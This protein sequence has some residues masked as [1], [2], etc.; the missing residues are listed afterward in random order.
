VTN[1]TEARAD[2]NFLQNITAS[3][4]KAIFGAITGSS[5][6]I[7]TDFTATQGNTTLGA[8]TGSGLNINGAITGSTIKVA[9]G[10]TLDKVVIGGTTPASGTFT[11]IKADLLD[12]KIIN[13]TVTTVTTLE[14]QDKK[15]IVG[16]SLPGNEAS[17]GGIQFGGT[18]SSDTLAS[19]LWDNLGTRLNF[20]I[21][22]TTQVRLADGSLV[23]TTNNDIDLGGSSNKFKDVYIAGST[24]GSAM[25]LTGRLSGAAGPQAGTNLLGNPSSMDIEILSNYNT[26]LYGPI[27]IAVGARL[28]IPETSNVKIVNLAD[29]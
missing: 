19:I 12:V 6:S 8:I 10:G 21:G 24:S 2:W 23:P 7:S 13:N 9:G 3:S 16:E 5:L 15:I 29:L 25:F 11:G 4:G 26:V 1:K 28:R 18:N 27:T 14:V 17:G 20:N 22:G